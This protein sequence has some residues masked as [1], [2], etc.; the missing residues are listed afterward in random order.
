MYNARRLLIRL[1]WA[2]VIFSV[3]CDNTPSK[4][5]LK[6]LLID[7]H[8]EQEYR[9]KPAMELFEITLYSKFEFTQCPN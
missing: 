7:P 8:P 3:L 4:L 9:A 6:L 2:I 5:D 1:L